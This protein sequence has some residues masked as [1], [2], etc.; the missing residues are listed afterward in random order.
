MY[1]NFL[2][3][4]LILKRKNDVFGDCCDVANFKQIIKNLSNFHKIKDVKIN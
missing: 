1:F 3:V 2:F 4:N